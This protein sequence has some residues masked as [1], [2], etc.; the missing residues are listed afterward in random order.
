MYFWS[1]VLWYL[2]FGCSKVLYCNFPLLA[3]GRIMSHKI[4]RPNT[5]NLLGIVWT[6]CINIR[7]C[8]LIYMWP[9]VPYPNLKAV[10]PKNTFCPSQHLAANPHGFSRKQYIHIYKK[11]TH[12]ISQISPP[13][14]TRAGEPGPASALRIE[15]PTLTVSSSIYISSSFKNIISWASS[16]PTYRLHNLLTPQ[17]RSGGEQPPTREHNEKNERTVREFQLNF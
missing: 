6:V 17:G 5:S 7:V 14:P 8:G 12:I 11:T 10:N 16:L 9:L 1:R 4:V 15:L 3:C 2:H 13:R